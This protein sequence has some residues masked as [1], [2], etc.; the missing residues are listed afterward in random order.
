MANAYSANVIVENMFAMCDENENLTLLFVSIVGHRS[1]GHAVK[2]ADR[3][4]YNGRKHA[5]KT[6]KGWHLCIRWK[7]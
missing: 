7:D 3:L 2:F 1:D 4:M 5:W 6:T